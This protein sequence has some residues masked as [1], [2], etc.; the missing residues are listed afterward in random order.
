MA[1][2]STY[3]QLGIKYPATSVSESDSTASGASA[4][5]DKTAR[6]EEMIPKIFL[7]ILFLSS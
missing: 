3:C 5:D 2:V 7:T 6:F 1:L 4:P